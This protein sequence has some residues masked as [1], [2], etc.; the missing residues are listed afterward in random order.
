MALRREVLDWALPIPAGVPMHDMWLGLV[1][2]RRGGV[3]FLPEP[4]VLY[5]RHA[6]QTSTAGSP[7]SLPWGERI[8]LRVRLAWALTA[9]MHGGAGP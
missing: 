7:S 8:A 3:C 6:Q 5:R 1:A 2:E 9:R 4:L